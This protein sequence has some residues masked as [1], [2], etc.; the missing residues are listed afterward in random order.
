MRL[1]K[2]FMIAY[3]KMLKTCKKQSNKKEMW[4]FQNNK[5]PT[6]M[7]MLNKLKKVQ[8]KCLT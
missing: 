8:F 4:Y 2:D 7:E 3:F 1:V 5:A 6:L